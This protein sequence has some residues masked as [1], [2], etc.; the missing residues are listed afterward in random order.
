MPTQRDTEIAVQGMKKEI[1]GQNN[2][3]SSSAPFPHLQRGT[4][5][6]TDLHPNAP[7]FSGTG[8]HKPAPS[9]ATPSQLPILI[10]L[11]Q[12]RLSSFRLAVPS[13]C[14]RE[15]GCVCW[16]SHGGQAFL[17]AVF[18]LLLITE[19]RLKQLQQ[20]IKEQCGFWHLRTDGTIGNS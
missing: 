14:R 19:I 6:S 4:A 5:L 15:K 3:C 10:A 16:G 20:L 12:H 11:H 7:T 8:S 17:P 9:A 2:S 18:K 1:W 13:V